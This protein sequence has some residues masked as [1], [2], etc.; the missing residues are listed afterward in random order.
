MGHVMP[1]YGELTLTELERS[2]TATNYLLA[3]PAVRERLP[4]DLEV[5]L[6]AF[7]EELNHERATR[8]LPLPARR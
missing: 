4:R 5:R 6:D 8:P 7:L 1:N 3:T 2:I